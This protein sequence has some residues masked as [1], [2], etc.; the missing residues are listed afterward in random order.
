MGKAPRCSARPDRDE[1]R[2]ATLAPFLQE[3]CAAPNT[4]GGVFLLVL[5]EGLRRR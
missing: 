1:S 2:F 5:L 4:Y 3:L